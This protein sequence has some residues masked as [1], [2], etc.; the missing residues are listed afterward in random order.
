[1]LPNP[2]STPASLV[3]ASRRA[4]LLAGDPDGAAAAL[5][6]A[7]AAAPMDVEARYWL[8]SAR[9]AAGDP[10]AFVALDE[11]RTLHAL[12]AA[13]DM[14]VDT[15]RCQA[16]PA[17]ASA[18]ADAL[19]AKK[20]VAMSSVVRRMA[21]AGGRLD[22]PNLLSYG[23]A[24]Q[25]QGRLDEACQ[26]FAAASEAAP[27]PAVDQFQIYPHLLAD[28]GEARHAAAARAWARR[29]AHARPPLPHRNPD[30]AGRRLRIGYVA[31][32][33]G[34][35]QLRQFITPLLENHDPAAVA[36]TLYPTDAPSEAGRWP[37]FIDIHPLGALDDA[38]A[39]ELIRRD[40]I[41]VLAD[42]WGHSAGSRLGVFAHKPAPV[43]VA[44]LNYIQ[45]TGLAEIDYVLQADRETPER[46]LGLLSERIWRIGPTFVAFRPAA[47]RPP[48]TP[49]PALASGRMVF[50]SFNHPAKLSEAALDGWSA[51]LRGA[52]AARLL[53]K[54]RYFE[55]PVLRRATQ[56]RF[57]ARGVA[58]ERLAFDGHSSGAAYYDMFRR[59][60]LM[61]DAWPA[62]GSTTT[63]EALSNG[64]PVLMMAEPTFAGLY[65]RNILEASGLSELVTTSPEQFVAAA[66]ALAGDLARLD[67]LRQRVRPGFEQGP[68]CDEVGFTRRVEAAFGEMF[69]LWR[70]SLSLQGGSDRVV[71]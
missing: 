68:V 41:D 47:D 27:A 55:D 71:A 48:T 19:Y 20:L 70:E 31:P 57:A 54:Y 33:F 10:G 61:L 50:G 21:L 64:V 28:N 1:M 8:A 37:D 63:L 65:T 18:I 36:V 42:C 35:H 44:W 51:V 53:L 40:G 3:V 59:V 69:D 6:A 66:L 7:V 45:T 62:G 29:H 67:A 2:D 4:Q 32:W 5:Q 34:E 9:L 14:G 49:T 30:R 56:A 22:G 17:Y 60:D 23:L 52:P 43:Q 12:L 15:A 58:P 39:A 26:A 16:D 25:H 24:L 11:A 13:R 46:L 38:A